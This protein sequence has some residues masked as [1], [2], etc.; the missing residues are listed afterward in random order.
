MKGFN[1]PEL[2]EFHRRLRARGWDTA[3]LA[4]AVGRSRTTVSRVLCGS[5]RRGPL[6]RKLVTMLTR[7]EIRLLDVAHSSTWNKNRIAKRPRWTPEKSE[8]FA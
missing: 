2:T 7:Q 5:R 8:E 6:W 1:P 4:A 3:T